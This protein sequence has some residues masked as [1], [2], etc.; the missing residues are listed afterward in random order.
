MTSSF[1][2]FWM[3]LYFGLFVQQ[4]YAL[5]QKAQRN[6]TK[7]T[8]ATKILGGAKNGKRTFHSD[9]VYATSF[10]R[11]GTLLSGSRDGTLIWWDIERGKVIRK[12]SANDAG[13]V[14]LASCQKGDLIALGGGDGSIHLVHQNRGEVIKTLGGH[15]RAV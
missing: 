6:D 8:E 7:P 5:C 1:H 13:I 9:S 10:S 3:T 11:G 14:S 15:R 2:C 4:S 12:L